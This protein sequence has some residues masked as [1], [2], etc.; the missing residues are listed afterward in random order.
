MFL[1]VDYDQMSEFQQSQ[2]D[3][4]IPM[5]QG[6]IDS[7]C[8]YSLDAQDYTDKRYSGSGTSIL[9]LGL[10]P[11][12]SIASVRERGSDGT[13]TDYTSSVEPLPDG[14]IQFKPE[15]GGTF[16][17]GT[18]NI[19]VSFN[20]GYETIPQD[21]AYAATYLA[22][23]NFN[24]VAWDLIGIK[25]QGATNGSTEYDSIE[26]PVMVKRVLDRYRKLSIL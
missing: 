24:K 26:L 20:G 5:V 17:S 14:S 13:Y 22:A 18:L 9:D 4:I 19:Y 12:N 2:L 25:S 16:T 15:V 1:N 21:I 23:I 3:L 8:G 11:V 7:Y 6:V 10:A